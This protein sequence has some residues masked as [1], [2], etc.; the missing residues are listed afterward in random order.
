MHDGIG[1]SF[2]TITSQ[3]ASETAGSDGGDE[4]NR[5]R[6][7]PN[8]PRRATRSGG[9]EEGEERRERGERGERGER[10]E[11][12]QNRASRKNAP[13]AFTGVPK[14]TMVAW[15]RLVLRVVGDAESRVLAKKIRVA[16][17][18]PAAPTPKL[19]SETMA[20]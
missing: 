15:G 6:A 1:T 3:P 8:A 17:S 14:T 18:T 10:E 13:P 5:R 12:C 16:A 7:S 2:G 19:T 4:D 20:S 9:L 11:S